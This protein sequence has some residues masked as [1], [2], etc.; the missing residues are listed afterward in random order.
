MTYRRSFDALRAIEL[1]AEVRDDAG[2]DFVSPISIFD[3]CEVLNVSVRFI[4][5]KSAEAIYCAGP[6]LAPTIIV[7]ALRPPQRRFFNCAHE[8]G[9]HFLEHGFTVDEFQSG[10]TQPTNELLADTFAAHLLMPRL[11]LANAFVVRGWD[12]KEPTPFQLLVVASHFAIGMDTLITH[13][14]RGLN[15]LTSPQADRLRKVRLPVLRAEILDR[16]EAARLV[17]VDKDYSLP[18]VDVDVGDLILAA[19][20]NATCNGPSIRHEGSCNTGSIFRA[21]APGTSDIASSVHGLP[22]IARVSRKPYIG[23]AKYRFL[24]E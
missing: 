1:A 13:L 20:G 23:L 6:G 17:V 10:A 8:L 16:A 22:L 18:S 24:E 21:I 7:S 19:P 11:G 5:T 4:D 12:I 15:L 3:L 9:H 2:L 14:E